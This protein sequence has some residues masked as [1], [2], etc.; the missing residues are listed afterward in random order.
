MSLRKN[1]WNLSGRKFASF[2]ASPGGGMLAA[3]FLH[4]SP[5]ASNLS[6]WALFCAS[7][8]SSISWVEVGPEFVKFAQC[9][10]KSGPR[11]GRCRAA[12]SQHLA[13]KNIG[14]GP[15]L[16]REPGPFRFQDMPVGGK[17][18]VT[19]AQRPPGSRLSDAPLKVRNLNHV[20]SITGHLRSEK[21]AFLIRKG[22]CQMCTV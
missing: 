10:R 13:N 22:T 7:E 3:Q 4:V 2:F 11:C 21:T 12:P 8:L 15:I 5:P 18:S 1:P 19:T 16:A 17:A 9:R 14:F 6:I 20:F